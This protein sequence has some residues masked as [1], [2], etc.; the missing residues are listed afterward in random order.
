MV[1]LFCPVCGERIGVYEIDKQTTC[2]NCGRSFAV[3][4]TSPVAA[5][6]DIKPKKPRKPGPSEVK[7]HGA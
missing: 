1:V 4:T 7:Q 6:A 2:P 3:V 5:E